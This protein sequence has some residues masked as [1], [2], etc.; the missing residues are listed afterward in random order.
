MILAG[1]FVVRRNCSVRFASN[2]DSDSIKISGR[3]GANCL[4]AHLYYRPRMTV[5]NVDKETRHE[6][7]G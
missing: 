3:A 5:A 4:L 6:R 2:R 7:E 1:F